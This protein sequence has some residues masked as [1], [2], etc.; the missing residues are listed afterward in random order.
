MLAG[1]FV[2]LGD[3]ARPDL[4]ESPLAYAAATLAYPYGAKM[5]R[6][7]SSTRVIVTRLRCVTSASK[8]GI[9]ERL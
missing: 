6:C 3:V 1:L 7:S 5:E 8:G 2:K 4:E 9:A